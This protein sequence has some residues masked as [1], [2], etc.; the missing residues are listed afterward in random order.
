MGHGRGKGKPGV[1]WERAVMLNG[2]LYN[3]YVNY[4]ML[5]LGAG[6]CSVVGALLSLVGCLGTFLA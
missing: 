5:I 1:M 3:R 2:F 6:R 4:G